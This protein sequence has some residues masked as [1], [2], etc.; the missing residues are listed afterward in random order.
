MPKPRKQRVS[1]DATPWYHCVYLCVRRALLCGT[2]QASSNGYEPR[3][4][5]Q[6]E[7]ILALPEIFAERR[8]N[9]VLH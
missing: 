3:R 9:N 2:D 4:C 1:L 7:R 8:C 6:E 5:W